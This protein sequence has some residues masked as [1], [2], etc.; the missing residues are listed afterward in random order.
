MCAPLG[1]AV[2]GGHYWIDFVLLSSLLIRIMLHFFQKAVPHACLPIFYQLSSVQSSNLAWE[3]PQYRQTA[4]K[5][6]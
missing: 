1:E 4:P 3:S 6:V 2:S 5:P